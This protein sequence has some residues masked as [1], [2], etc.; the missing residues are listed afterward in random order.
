MVAPKPEQLL[1]G[2]QCLIV[3]EQVLRAAEPLEGCALLLGQ[4]QGQ[5]LVLQRIW[6]CCNRWEPA[7]ER[8]Q[9]FQLDPREQLLAQRWGRERG[10]QVLGSAHSHPGSPAAPSR[11]DRALCLGPTLMMIRSGLPS[12]AS[13]RAPEAEA[14]LAPLRAWWLLEPDAEGL[15]PIQPLELKLL[16]EQAAA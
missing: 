10:L 12:E 4:K 13:S 11:T 6:P 2:R 5:C 16:P 9:R 7:A 8:R 15:A 3:L 1:T 14:L